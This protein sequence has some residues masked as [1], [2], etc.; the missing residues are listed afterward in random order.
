MG[1]FLLPNPGFFFAPASQ[2]KRQCSYLFFGV[3]FMTFFT[4]QLSTFLISEGFQW[5]GFRPTNVTNETPLDFR[6]G[7]SPFAS[8]F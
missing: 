3:V 5:L 8:C 4:P 1:S 6:P 7:A 2:R